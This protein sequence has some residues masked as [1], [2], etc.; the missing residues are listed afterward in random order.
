MP[1]KKTGGKFEGRGSRRPS[2][3]D[4][5]PQ[6]FGDRSSGRSFDRGSYG[7]R[8]RAGPQLFD[9]TCA[10]CGT[11]TQVPFKPTGEKP[12]YCRDCFNKGDDEGPRKQPRSGSGDVSLREINEKLDKIM[13]ALDIE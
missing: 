7:S 6:R 13:Q 4:E 3:R 5:R 12:V 10:R 9:V 11:Q 1:F 8:D 2:S